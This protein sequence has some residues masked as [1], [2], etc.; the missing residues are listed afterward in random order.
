MRDSTGPVL[1]KSL[2]LRGT[3]SYPAPLAFVAFGN[4]ESALAP[5]AKALRTSRLLGI[6]MY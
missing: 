6:A 5:L 2:E 4:D 3:G 1:A